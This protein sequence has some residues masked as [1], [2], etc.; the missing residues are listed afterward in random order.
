MNTIVFLDNEG[1]IIPYKWMNR[2]EAIDVEIKHHLQLFHE[3]FY[4]YSSLNVVENTEKALWLGDSSIQQLYVKRKNEGWYNRVRM[5]NINQKITID[6]LKLYG[7]DEPYHFKAY[8]TLNIA[9]GNLLDAYHFESEGQIIF[10]DRNYPLNP[11]GLLI[12]K[13]MEV[14]ST[15]IK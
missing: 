7:F 12:T 9:Q 2:K 14:S 3:Y 10:T 1:D 5:Y 13:Y 4:Q 15:K 6:S 8:C 11:H